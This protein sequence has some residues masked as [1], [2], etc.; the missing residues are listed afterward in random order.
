MRNSS[1]YLVLIGLEMNDFLVNN[2]NIICLP[3]EKLIFSAV[4]GPVELIFKKFE[5]KIPIDQPIF[6][7][8]IK[9]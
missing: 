1:A 3:I 4:L 9:I 5:V 8:R 7:N 6:E 2:S